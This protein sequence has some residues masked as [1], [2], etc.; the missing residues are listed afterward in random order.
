MAWEIRSPI[1]SALNGA[2]FCDDRSGVGDCPPDAGDGGVPVVGV[3][4][5]IGFGA[6]SVPAVPCLVDFV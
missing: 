3:A 1:N 2:L 6:R 4:L 5:D